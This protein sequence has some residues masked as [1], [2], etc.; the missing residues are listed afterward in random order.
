M[1]INKLASVVTISRQ[2]QRSIRIESDLGRIESL[3]GYICHA[4]SRM[5][6]ENLSRQVAETKQRSFTI[7]GPFG[8]GKSSLA[9]CFASALGLHPLC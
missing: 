3:D 2:Y 5:A 7:T 9:I 8:G 6:L 4:T 1:V